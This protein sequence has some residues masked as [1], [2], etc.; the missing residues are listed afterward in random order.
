MSLVYAISVCSSLIL[1]RGVEMQNARSTSLLEC[2]QEKYS[3]RSFSAL[4]SKLEIFTSCF[5]FFFLP[6]EFGLFIDSSKQ[7]ALCLLAAPR[8]AGDERCMTRA[9]KVM[10]R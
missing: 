9:V 4:C 5:F 6:L 1:E 3:C 8:A 2:N 10:K 7:T